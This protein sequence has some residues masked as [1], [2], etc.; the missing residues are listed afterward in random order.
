MVNMVTNV[1]F[2]NTF[3]RNL[4]NERMFEFSDICPNTSGLSA[5]LA[6]PLSKR[7]T[8][9]MINVSAGKACFS[10]LATGPTE[11]IIFG[12]LLPCWLRK[13]M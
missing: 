5:F 9:H 13:E 8:R 2:K 12:S 1:C 11:I 7:N 4:L 10:P 6:F 3:V